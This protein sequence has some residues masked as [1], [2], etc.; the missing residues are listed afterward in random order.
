MVKLENIHPGEILLEEFLNPLDITPYCLAKTI[1]VPLT[2]II[3]IIRRKRRITPG[4]ALRLSAFFG[5]TA[6]FWLN[7]QGEYD[8]REARKQIGDELSEVRSYTTLFAHDREK[9]IV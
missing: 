9:R 1:H 6:Q 8:L 7:L 5:T 3:M 4:T 2:R